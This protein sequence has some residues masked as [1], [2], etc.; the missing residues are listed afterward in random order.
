LVARTNGFWCL[1][2]FA[3][4]LAT[5]AILVF[6]SGI[7]VHAWNHD[8]SGQEKRAIT[9][10]DSLAM[11]TLE[12]PADPYAG[13]PAPH[14]SPD[15]KYFVLVVRTANVEQ[16]TNDASVLLYRSA[17]VFESPQPEVLVKMASSSS[18]RYA[19]SQIRWL[20]DSETLVFL[21]DTLT[22]C[23]QIYQ[24]N[25]RT[26]RLLKRTNHPTAI[27]N[28]DITLDGAEIAYVAEPPEQWPVPKKQE[29][30]GEVVITGQDLGNI[31]AGHHFQPVGQ[32]VFWT[33]SDGPPSAIPVA[34][35]YFV[36]QTKISCSP[37][38]RYIVFPA[39]VRDL[40]LH[41][42]WEGYDEPMVKQVFATHTFKDRISPLQQYLLFDTKS[43]V[44]SS[45]VEAPAM[46]PFDGFSWAVDGQSV[47]LR[48]YLPLDVTDAVERKARERNKYSLQVTLP[49]REFRKVSAE[50]LPANRILKAPFELTVDQDLNTPPRLFVS[51]GQQ[52]KLLLDLNPQFTQLDFG[53]VRTIEW[54]VDGMA[55]IGGLYLPPDY[56]PG[57]R[58][59]LVIQTHGFVPD[60]FSMDGYSEWSSGFAAR[61]LAARGILV[62]QAWRFKDQKDYDQVS[63]NRQ[64]GGTEEE[65]ILNFNVLAYE[66]AIDRLDDEGMIDRDHVGIVGFSRTACSVGYT[67]THSHYQFAAGMLV[68]GVSCGY[69]EE[70]AVPQ[71]SRDINLVNGG[72]PPFGAGLGLWMRNSPGF[73]L[74]EV[75][76]PVQL[77]S[78][79][80][81]SVL[82]AWEWFTGLSLQNKPVDF[83][84]VP[85]GYHLGVRPSQRMF[86][87]QD[88]VDW[89]A[90]WLQ[91][92]ETSDPVDS[93]RAARNARWRELR[94]K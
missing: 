14:F 76:T 68:D 56:V 50:E 92:D 55:V 60:K 69:F 27:T 2:A 19:I 39:L 17:D 35:G 49:G 71:E 11:A 87:Q 9:V 65:S 16:N 62:L 20:A 6:N 10:A 30:S 47:F 3:A 58:Y 25:I 77:V 70:I 91:R 52:K 28:F 53:A 22:E 8:V 32:Q 88:M 15:G 59:P 44:V 43:R 81:Y 38:G 94:T 54:K 18:E 41:R 42:G 75:R 24:F 29:S 78:L 46:N 72:A 57:K 74:S 84:M 67:L 31:L 83:M 66:R 1:V 33:R 64:L 51:S 85:D 26:R 48:S 73:N 89:F 80:D 82:M 34:S 86:T 40:Q 63:T 4:R 79:Q 61:P 12:F 36:P 21:G 90:F 7:N 23:S 37:T 93:V 5:T 45:L 13:S